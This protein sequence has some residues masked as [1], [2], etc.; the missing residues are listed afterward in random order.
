MQVYSTALL[1]TGYGAFSL[2]GG[3][4]RIPR[5]DNPDV[6]GGQFLFLTV[7]RCVFVR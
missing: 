6:V 3:F 2:Y 1:I 4:H 5:G 7:T